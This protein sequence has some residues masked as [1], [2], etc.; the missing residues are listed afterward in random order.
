MDD[1]LGFINNFGNYAK[2]ENAIINSVTCDAS[3]SGN[4]IIVTIKTWTERHAIRTN[5]LTQQYK[6][7]RRDISPNAV[8][9]SSGTVPGDPQRVNIFTPGKRLVKYQ[10]RTLNGT[11]SR[12]DINDKDVCT[13][14]FYS[15][16]MAQRFKLIVSQVFS[17][18]R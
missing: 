16:D 7:D 15:L 4:F 2:T 13:I 1:F 17:A 6:F 9:E 10:M 8:I 14:T 3:I 12:E 18:N 11:E 5:T